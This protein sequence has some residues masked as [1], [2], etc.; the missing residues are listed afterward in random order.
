MLDTILKTIRE[1]AESQVFVHALWVEGSVAQGESDEYSDL[2]VWLEVDPDKVD[3]T[4]KVVK[5]A[6]ATIG[7]INLEYEVHKDNDQRH[8]IYHIEGTSEFLTIDV[9]V[10]PFPGTSGFD[11]GVDII[12]IIFNKDAKFKF[13]K[14]EP[15]VFNEKASKQRMLDYY[16][17]MRPN[18]LKNI[19]RNKP[20]E[21]KIYYDN[22]VEMAIKYLRRKNQ[23]D[24]KLSYNHK[25]LHR[26]LPDQAQKFEYFIFVQPG[27]LEAKLGELAEWLKNLWRYSA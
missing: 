1:A 9:N 16:R 19:R 10:Q 26:D 13:Y 22:I 15:K 21:A 5:N 3:E 12:N 24:A 27:E 8:I 23:L 14:S 20:I 7:P 4:Y 25:H 17:A 18:V 6:L 11:E 2:D